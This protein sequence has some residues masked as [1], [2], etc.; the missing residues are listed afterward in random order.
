MNA[1]KPEEYLH[2]MVEIPRDTMVVIYCG[3]PV[4]HYGRT[5]AEFMGSFGFT[6]LLLYDDGWDDWTAAG[7]PVS[8]DPVPPPAAGPAAGMENQ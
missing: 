7:L 5:L 8:T 2:W 3:N 6:N 1:M 4:C